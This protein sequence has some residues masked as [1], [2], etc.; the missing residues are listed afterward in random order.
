MTL[1]SRWFRRSDPEMDK[2]E[3]AG[4]LSARPVNGPYDYSLAIAG[5]R[6]AEARQKRKAKLEAGRATSHRQLPADIYVMPTRTKAV[7]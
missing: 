6:R 5:K 4:R 3:A 1:F 7:K 2:L